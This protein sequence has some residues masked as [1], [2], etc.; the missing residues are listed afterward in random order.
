MH[1]LSYEPQAIPEFEGEEID[2]VTIEKRQALGTRKPVTITVRDD[3]L[4]PCT[5][6]FHIAIHQQQHNYAARSPPEAPSIEGPL[7]E[8]SPDAGDNE[9]QLP[10]QGESEGGF[11]YQNAAFALQCWIMVKTHS[12]PLLGG[13]CWTQTA[14]SPEGPWD[15]PDKTLIAIRKRLVP[16]CKC[17]QQMSQGPVWWKAELTLHVQADSKMGFVS[18]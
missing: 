16:A 17:Q 14:V 7:E 6:H 10:G 12:C 13:P 15:I 1:L 11:S 2:V 3:P 4:D 5:K 18:Q 9:P 8:G